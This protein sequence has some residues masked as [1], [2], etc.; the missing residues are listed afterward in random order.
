MNKDYAHSLLRRV[1]A[2]KHI[3]NAQIA[4]LEGE[5]YLLLADGK[6]ALLTPKAVDLLNGDT[7][8]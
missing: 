2:G 8:A 5:G 3:T 1:A 4:A 6:A 7:G